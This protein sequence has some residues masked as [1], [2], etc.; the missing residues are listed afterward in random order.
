MQAKAQMISPPTCFLTADSKTNIYMAIVAVTVSSAQDASA[1]TTL[2]LSPQGLAD[3]VSTGGIPCLTFV[4][5][6]AAPYGKDAKLSCSSKV[7]VIE[8]VTPNGPEHA[9]SWWKAVTR[10][11]AGHYS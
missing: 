10:S 4:E 3:F 6:I 7:S 5:V 2:M 9:M 8:S 1:A 11:N